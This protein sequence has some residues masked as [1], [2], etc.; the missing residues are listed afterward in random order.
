MLQANFFFI[1]CTLPG[2]KILCLKSSLKLKGVK[3]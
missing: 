3:E 1:G 2:E